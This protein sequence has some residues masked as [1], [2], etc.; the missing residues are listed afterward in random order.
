M[1][2][3]L[4]KTLPVAL[5]ALAFAATADAQ[6]A[7]GRAGPQ[8]APGS[9]YLG[10]SVGDSDLDTALKLFIGDQVGP[11]VGWEAAYVDFGD[12]TWVRS[13]GTSNSV[14]AWG[15]GA[16]IVGHLPFNSQFSG[17]AKL[18]AY[19]VKGET[20]V[21]TPFGASSSSDSDVELAAGVGLRLALNRQLSL[22]AEFES[23]G[24]EGGDL[25]SVGLQ[26]HF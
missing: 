15:L 18:G 8:S 16:S 4:K 26:F 13:S 14:E 25:V 17:F 11:H 23:Y 10:A 22:R 1:T 21:R 6:S 2:M 12:K 24:G 9:A 19:Y 5:L 3:M 7:R 20:T